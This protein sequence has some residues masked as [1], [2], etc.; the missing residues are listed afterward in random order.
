M[1]FPKTV[2]WA[3]A[4]T[5]LSNKET[6][7]TINKGLIISATEDCARYKGRKEN[8]AIIVAPS[9]PHWGVV[10]PSI[11]ACRR[12]IPRLIAIC[13]LSV[14]TIA[15][16]TNIPMAI[17]KAA[18][19]VLFN[20]TPINCMINSVPPIQN[21]NELPIRIPARRLRLCMLA[22]VTITTDSIRFRIKPLFASRAIWSSGYSVTISI[23]TGICS[24]SCAN[25]NRTASP[26]FTTS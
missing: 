20:P 12:R 19:E 9:N 24:S 22:Q 6:A 7:N 21:I 14:T 1:K 5:Q 23:P 13:A 4:S 8:T 25:F 2:V 3:N 11:K 26:A 16:S 10:A 17:I 15:L 18:K